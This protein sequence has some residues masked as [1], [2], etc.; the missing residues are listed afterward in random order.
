M[1]Y[2]LILKNGTLV[3]PAE[4]FQG[5]I[6]VSNGKIV[7]AGR[8]ENS[9]TADEV[10]D[11]QGKHILPGIIDAHVHFREPGLTEKEDFES[12]SMAAAFGGITTIADMPNVLPVTSTLTRFNE[13]ACIAGA[14]SYV[15]FALFALLA[16]DNE[17]EMEGLCKAG[18]LGF[19]VFLGTST[20]DIAAPSPGVLFEQMKKSAALG[21][22]IGFHAETNGLNSHFTA[23]WRD[24]RDLPEGL[25]LSQARPVISEVLAVQTAIC[26][27][28]YTGAKIHIHH[29]TSLDGARLVAEAKQKGVKVSAE[30]CPHYL[31][32]DANHGRAHKVYPPVREESHRNGLW[33]ALVNGTIDMIASDHAPHTAHDKELPL[34]EAP[35]GLCGVETSVRLLLN[36]VNRGKITLNDFVRL[37]SEAPAK[38]WGVYPRKG[39][40]L[41]GADA[42][43]TVVD[44][45]KKGKISAGG[46]HSKSKTSPYDGLETQGLPMAVIVRGAFVMRDGELTGEK[47]YGTLISPAL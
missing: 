39:N 28:Q 44:M 30:T 4:S 11:A 2:D 22:R 41:P 9:D 42:D 18:A 34:W 20:G 17:G 33:D 36:E 6:A 19:K 45:K 32:L 12:G 31:L 27:A 43:F 3:T 38:I 24:R 5:D 7:Q 16:E 10:Y 15:D 21:M 37:A 13:K 14:K 40:L 29:V 25:L 1:H 46:L 35:A 8:L 47:G 26:Y 23:V